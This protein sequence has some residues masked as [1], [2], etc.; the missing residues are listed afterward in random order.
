MPKDDNLNVSA[1]FS[2]TLGPLRTSLSI[3]LADSLSAKPLSTPV[4]RGGGRGAKLPA[5]A[6]PPEPNLWVDGPK[7]KFSQS[8]A[9]YQISDSLF[10]TRGSM[11]SALAPSG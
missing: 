11:K 4:L 1:Y 7:P 9:A 8:G 5:I 3:D 10:P 2:A 6:G